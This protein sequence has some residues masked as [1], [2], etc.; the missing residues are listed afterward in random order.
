MN[1]VVLIGR[2]TKDMA[3]LRGSETKVGLF[4]IA[5]NRKYTNSQGKKEADFIQVKVFKKLAENC[6]KY[7][8]K[9]SLVSVEASLQTGKFTRDG[10]DNYFMEVIADDVRF[11]D[12]RNRNNNSSNDEEGSSNNNDY[13]GDPFAGA[14]EITP[15]NDWP[16]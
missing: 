1:N 15:G 10:K 8:S 11:L 14:T 13:D 4:T 5:V 16:F 3:D 12:T 2:L 7:L 9:G 6:K